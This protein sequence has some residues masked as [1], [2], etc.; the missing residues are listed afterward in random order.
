MLGLDARELRLVVA[1]LGAG[2]SVT[3]IRDGHSVDTSM[4]FTPLEGLAMATRS[5]TVDPGALL[6]LQT[7]R[8]ISV[9][10]M[11]RDLE[12]ASGLLALSGSPDMRDVL[13]RASAGDPRAV[14]ARDVFLHRC[15]RCIAAVAASLDR[16]DALVF[17][18][19]IGEHAEAIRAAVCARLPILGVAASLA[20]PT[21]ED[22]IV[23]DTDARVAV[24]VVHA[25]EDVQMAHEVRALLSS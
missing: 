25:R 19:G 21:A 15:A 17:T 14:L 5:G 2:A 4:G 24:L 7:V 8:G 16:L 13:E 12:Q 1:H 18:G 20:A 6:W 23:S 10:D 3:A 11:S 9:G 22:S